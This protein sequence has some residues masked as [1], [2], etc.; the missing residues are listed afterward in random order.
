MPAQKAHQSLTGINALIF[1]IIHIN[2]NFIL[3]QKINRKIHKKEIFV[4]ASVD[5]DNVI[6]IFSGAGGFMA[7][8]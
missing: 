3:W 4:S 6:Q 1:T 7:V 2:M 5:L 8:L